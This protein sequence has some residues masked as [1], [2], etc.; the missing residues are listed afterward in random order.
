M[1]KSLSA[2]ASLPRNGS[3]SEGQ[4]VRSLGGANNIRAATTQ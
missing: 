2:G 4:A 3:I 1:R